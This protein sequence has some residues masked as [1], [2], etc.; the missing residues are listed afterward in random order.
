ME[1]RRRGSVVRRV[2]G[3]G[4]RLE[5]PPWPRGYVND[6]QQLGAAGTLVNDR[7]RQA[8]VLGCG[9]PPPTFAASYLPTRRP[10]EG[11]VRGGLKPRGVSTSTCYCRQPATSEDAR[12][13]ATKHAHP[14]SPPPSRANSHPALL[15]H[16][17]STGRCRRNGTVEAGSDRVVRPD[18]RHTPQAVLVA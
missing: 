14:P 11:Q 6:T 12:E 2:G 4:R 1:E 13:P 8:R 9:E 15:K 7:P 10:S 5:G 3:D 17:C 16:R 18:L